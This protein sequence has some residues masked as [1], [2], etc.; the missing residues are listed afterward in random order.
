MQGARLVSTPAMNST[1]SAVRGLEDSW[2]DMCVKSTMVGRDAEEGCYLAASLFAMIR[3]RLY[4]F[5]SSSSKR[6]S[7]R[8][9]F[10]CPS[11]NSAFLRISGSLLVRATEMSAGTP[12]SRGRCD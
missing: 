9:S 1:G 12:S 3:R 6:L 10:D 8:G 2:L 5:V 7:A 4:F 11:Q